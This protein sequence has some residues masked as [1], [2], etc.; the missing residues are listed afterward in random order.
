MAQLQTIRK[1]LQLQ[2]ILKNIQQA[3]LCI[4]KISKVIFKSIVSMW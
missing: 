4:L 2:T 1:S 3:D